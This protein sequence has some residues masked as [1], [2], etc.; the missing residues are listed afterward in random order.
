[1]CHFAM[2]R[3]IAH[4]RSA[5]KGNRFPPACPPTSS[6]LLTMFNHPAFDIY[7]FEDIPLDRDCFL[8]DES[9]LEEYERSLLATFSGSAYEN[10]VGYISYAAVRKINADSIEVSWYPNVHDRFH[11]VLITVPKSEI[12]ICVASWRWDEKPH[13]FVKAGWL[14]KL[15]VKAYSVFGFIDA[16]GVKEALQTGTIT[17]DR[18][19]ALRNEID[20]LGSS[21][22]QISFI[23]FAD[24]VL[25]K[26]NWYVGHVHSEVTYTYEPEIFLT[27]VKDFQRIFQATLG[28]N[29]YAVLTQGNN[30]Y[31]D[32][33][34]LHISPSLNHVCLNSLGLP[35]AQLLAIDQAVKKSL[36]DGRHL[37][38]ELYMDELFFRSLNFSFAFS[39]K[40]IP[41]YTYRNKMSG[42]SAFYYPAQ[43]SQ[44]LDNLATDS[45]P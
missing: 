1:M 41:K 17:R 32:D 25:V 43:L 18:L 19:I 3:Y 14:D 5:A 22:P 33:S 38:S 42:T 11:E 34:L 36:R 35:F 28:L 12:V 39:E 13:I 26:S 9:Y 2:G 15:H 30:E 21:Y 40:T 20:L 16:I 24:S 29:V 6:S 27:V 10:P 4:G 7:S 23:S 37:P 45:T 44:V 8:M 31:Y